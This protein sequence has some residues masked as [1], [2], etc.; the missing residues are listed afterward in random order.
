MPAVV[1]AL[2]ARGVDFRTHRDEF[3]PDALDPEWLPI[4][5]GRGWV[6]LTR[7]TRI[8][9]VALERLA[10][11]TLGARQFVI[12]GAKL[13]AADV[14]RLL[15][16][17]WNRIDQLARRGGGGFIAHVTHSGVQIM[18]EFERPKRHGGGEP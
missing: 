5:C 16:D 2:A 6:I 12:R 8:R 3:A 1:A 9:H 4:V 7:D 18:V 10:L 13:K 17:K 11:E 14:A 15:D